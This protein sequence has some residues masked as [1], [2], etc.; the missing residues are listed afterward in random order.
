MLSFTRSAYRVVRIP[1]SGSG[2]NRHRFSRS[3]SGPSTSRYV[4]SS[5]LKSVS[6]PPT[7]LWGA[8]FVSAAG[9]G[10]WS[11]SSLTG[12]SKKKSEDVDLAK[13]TYLVCNHQY[14]VLYS[15]IWQL[16]R[17]WGLCDMV[18]CISPKRHPLG[19]KLS[20][21]YF[22][23]LAEVSQLSYRNFGEGFR[24]LGLSTSSL[25]SPSLVCSS[26]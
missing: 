5:A 3:S 22:G 2:R 17:I 15:T 7:W 20:S 12:S 21:A 10:G 19:T 13:Q 23:L 18:C 14:L 16:K 24:C 8:A 11:L 1:S 26:C 9:F 4:S 6:G 25:P